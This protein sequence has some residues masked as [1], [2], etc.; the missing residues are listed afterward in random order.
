MLTDEELYE[1]FSKEEIA[2]LKEY[3]KEAEQRW[4]PKLVKE[5]QAKV[6][7]MSKE[8]W[9][10]IGEEGKSVP[11]DMAKLLGKKDAGDPEVQTVIGR[12]HAW[13]SNFYTPTAEMYRG[14]GKMY[15][16]DPRFTAYYEKFVPGLADFMKKAIDY[17]CDHSLSTN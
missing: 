4:D 3:E 9:K 10:A 7:R 16:D 13:I 17:Y 5:S 1:G 14:L 12:H 6:R 11:T 15:V 2:Q 8:Q